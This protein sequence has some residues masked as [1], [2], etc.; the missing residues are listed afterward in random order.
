MT[1]RKGYLYSFA[2]NG[3]LIYHLITTML[4]AICTIGQASVPCQ[5]RARTSTSLLAQPPAFETSE[6]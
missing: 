3:Q 6:T 5:I 4:T 2:K 1:N